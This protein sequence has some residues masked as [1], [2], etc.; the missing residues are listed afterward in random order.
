MNDINYIKP[1]NS[2]RLIEKKNKIKNLI[3]ERITTIS[4][5]QSLRNGNTID[6]ELVLMICNC[7]EN[8]VKKKYGIDK[9]QFVIE[10][11]NDIFSGLNQ[12]EVDNISNTCQFLFDNLLIQTVLIV[13]KAKSDDINDC[14]VQKIIDY[15]FQKLMRYIIV[16][17]GLQ[18]LLISAIVFIL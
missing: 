17:Y 9:K 16:K 3:K 14:V 15:L 4:N 11:V 13:D 5:Y 18:C 2:L 12:I 10:I 7:V 8:L 1:K 6:Q